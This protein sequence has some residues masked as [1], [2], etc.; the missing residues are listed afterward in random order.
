[1]KKILIVNNN[2]YMGGVQK[3]LVNLL[4]EIHGKY[5]ITLLLF[6]KGGALLDGIPQD[7]K[8]IEAAYP[9][10]CWGINASDAKSAKQKLGRAFFAAMS[11][12]I[13]RRAAIKLTLLRKTKLPHF[14]VAISYLHGGADKV[15][16]GGCNEFVLNCVDADKKIAFLHCDYE[17]S[18]ADTAYNAKLY[19]RFDAI[20]ACSN[21]CRDA[22]LRKLQELKGKTFVVPNCQNYESI[23]KSAKSNAVSMEG[24]RLNFVCVSRFGR[25]KGLLR[26]IKAIASTGDKAKLFRCFFIGDGKELSD[27]KLL[28]NELGL[29]DT[30]IFLGELSEPYGYMKAADVLLIPSYSEAAP[31]VIGEAASLS[32]PI[33]STETSSAKE[34]IENTGFG[35][36]VENSE[37]GIRDGIIMLLNHPE[38]IEEKRAFLNNAS[39]DNSLSIKR[40]TDLVD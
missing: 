8:V 32:M 28:A 19:R 25:E 22:F 33:L 13:G 4:D 24:D 26:A 36:V 12:T 20:S 3:S 27:A 2:M 1:M 29:D 16:Y 9:L 17:L 18:G 21:G 6:H 23:E 5:E 38:Y 39:F 31:M 7:V 34:M 10:N 30:V 14:D 37:E 11:R 35:W 40:F 15:F